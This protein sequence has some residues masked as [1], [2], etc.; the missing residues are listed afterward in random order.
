MSETKSG[1]PREL[2]ARGRK[3]AMQTETAAGTDRPTT[4]RGESLAAVRSSDGDAVSRMVESSAT[5]EG[6]TAPEVFTLP[7]LALFVLVGLGSMM[8]ILTI[9]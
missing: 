3:A 7:L 4:R 8:L 6:L 9:I 5:Q 1:A 2:H